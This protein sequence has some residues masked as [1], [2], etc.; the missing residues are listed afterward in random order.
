MAAP[1]PA[2]RRLFAVKPRDSN[3]ESRLATAVGVNVAKAVA[4][5][6]DR[7]ADDA[8]NAAILANP[9]AFATTQSRDASLAIASETA[10]LVYRNTG[11]TPVVVVARADGPDVSE[12]LGSNASFAGTEAQIRGQNQIEAVLLPRQELWV[13]VRALNYPLRLV[14]TAI[15]LNGKAGVFG[16]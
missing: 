1:K 2:P 8:Y 5:A 16:G 6:L 12:V 3:R 7:I 11:L 13:A 9:T 4:E 14:P 10:V 15:S